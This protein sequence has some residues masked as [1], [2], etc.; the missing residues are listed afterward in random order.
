[1]SV[2]DE[3]RVRPPDEAGARGRAARAGAGRA[4]NGAAGGAGRP[5]APPALR[6][7]AAAGRPGA[8]AGEPAAGASARRAARRARSQAPQGDAAGAQAPPDR[9]RH[10]F[11]V[12][13]ARSGRGAHH[14]RPDRAHAAGADRADRHP[15]RPLRPARSRY[16][17]DFI[18]DTNLL[19]GTVVE[20]AGRTG[21]LRVGRRLLRGT[22]VPRRARRWAEAW[23]TVRPE[24]IRHRWPTVARRGTGTVLAG[25]V[26][27]AVYA[28]PAAP[29]ARDLAGRPADLVA[30]APPARRSIWRAR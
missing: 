25:T 3:H 23:L 15:A 5:R 8:R 6:R 11:R 7:A 29:G 14:E 20:S 10:H 1:M 12:R 26:D 28:G 13:D 21:T 17:A 18:G 9:P 19:P 4:R 30:S 16:V 24:A 2:R 27:D 22:C